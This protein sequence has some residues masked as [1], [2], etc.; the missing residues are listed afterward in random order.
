MVQNTE[1]EWPMCGKAGCLCAWIQTGPG[2]GSR[3]EHKTKH[4]CHRAANQPTA[5]TQQF[6]KAL[7]NTP[8]PLQ[9]FP[10]GS[11]SLQA[12]GRTL[13]PRVLTEHFMLPA[14]HGEPGKRKGVSCTASMCFQQRSEKSMDRGAWWARV[15]GSQRFDK[16]EPVSTSSRRFPHSDGAKAHLI[17]H[18][19]NPQEA[20][21]SR[22]HGGQR[23]KA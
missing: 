11:L 16:A 21:G 10:S 20:E 6:W 12:Q 18:Q 1:A 8:L 9:H 4:Y 3:P 22:Y 7:E 14:G 23:M 2:T 13:H 15:Q 17:V 19:S 5:A